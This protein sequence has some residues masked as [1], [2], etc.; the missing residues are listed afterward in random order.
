LAAAQ[1][2]FTGRIAIHPDQVEPINTAFMPSEEAVA[3]ARRVVAAFEAAPDAG[4]VGLD[5][6]MLDM[7]HLQQAQ[8][9][10]ARHAA[11][12]SRHAAFTR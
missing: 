6:S 4:A 12:A 7:P 8:R 10:L 3:H 5:G 1:E 2:G 9:L 11:F